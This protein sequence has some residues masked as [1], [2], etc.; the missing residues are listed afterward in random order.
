ME[1]TLFGIVIEVS[2]EQPVKASL[3]ME[4]TLFGIV[5]EVRPVQPVN[6]KSPIAVTPSGMFME[7]HSVLSFMLYSNRILLKMTKSLPSQRLFHH[8]VSVKV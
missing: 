6:A 5:I 7:K 3:P 2:P 1:V 4:V 8:G